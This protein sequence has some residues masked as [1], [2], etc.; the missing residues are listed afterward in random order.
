MSGFLSLDPLLASAGCHAPARSAVCVLAALVHC[1]GSPTL[2][3]LKGCEA[4]DE[5][6]RSPS[7][8]AK[9]PHTLSDPRTARTDLVPA[10]PIRRRRRIGVFGRTAP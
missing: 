2:A 3:R 9:L 6:S 7:S 4:P 10:A 8:E 5:G 1:L